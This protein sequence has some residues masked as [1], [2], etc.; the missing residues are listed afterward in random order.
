M[1]AT[2]DEVQME[3]CSRQLR[4]YP[5]IFTNIRRAYWSN[6]TNYIF[7]IG[8]GRDIGPEDVSVFIECHRWAPSF[9]SP[10][11]SRSSDKTDYRY[12]WPQKPYWSN[13]TLTIIGIMHRLLQF[14]AKF[15]RMEVLLIWKLCKG[16]LQRLYGLFKANLSHRYA[17]TRI[18]GNRCAGSSTLAKC[19]Q[20]YPAHMRQVHWMCPLQKKPDVSDGPNRYFSRS[21]HD[22]KHSY[23]SKLLEILPVR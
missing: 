15:C 10:W 22:L 19:P 17:E 8:P 21:L 16:Q 6:L 2:T 5:Y 20:R 4:Q 9:H 1:D 3:I 7:I 11:L 14:G 12:T 13:G 18:I 23:N